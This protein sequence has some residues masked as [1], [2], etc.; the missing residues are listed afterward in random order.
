MHQSITTLAASILLSVS[1][2]SQ[3]LADYYP[4]ATHQVVEHT[5]YSLEYSE[6]HEQAKWVIYF[7][8][9]DGDTE[10]SDNFREDPLVSSQ[11]ATLDDYKASGYDRGHLA[12]AGDMDFNTTAMRESFYMSNMS[13]QKPGFNRGIWKSLEAL[14]RTWAINA[15]S[16]NDV[17]ITGPILTESCGQIGQNVTV[18]CAYYKIYVD[19]SRKKAIGFVLPNE[20]SS[21]PLESFVHSIDEIEVMTGIDF[22]HLLDDT[23]EAD[24]EDD[25]NIGDWNWDPELQQNNN[26]TLPEPT[27]LPT[28]QCKALTQS[29]KQCSRKAGTTGYCW[30]HD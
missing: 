2:L 19:L 23:L 20:S 4:T 22:F 7:A 1:A 15:N 28:Q 5:Y 9:V 16:P 29:G 8:G 30:Q 21:L 27:D 18:P 25:E 24:F 13:P 11:S 12:P 6:P 26:S 3:S 17:I 10:R 14:T